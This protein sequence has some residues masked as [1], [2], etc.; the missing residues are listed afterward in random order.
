MGNNASLN[1][2]HVFGITWE[3]IDETIHTLFY[4]FLNHF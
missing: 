2:I 3:N 4:F 1:V